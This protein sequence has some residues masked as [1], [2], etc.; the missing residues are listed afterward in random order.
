[1]K[2]IIAILAIVIALSAPALA[3]PPPHFT[4]TYSL[5][6]A[7]DPSGI[8]TN[9]VRFWI[10]NVTNR[11]FSCYQ[12]TWHSFAVDAA[13]PSFPLLAPNGTLSAPSYSF[14]SYPMDGM[15][16]T[17]ASGNQYTSLKGGPDAGNRG[18]MRVGLQSKWTVTAGATEYGDI[19]FGTSGFDLDALGTFSVDVVGNAEIISDGLVDLNSASGVSGAQ[20]R[21]DSAG[22][23][24]MTANTTGISA[25]AI[26]HATGSG[27]PVASLSISNGSVTASVGADVKGV[28]VLTGGSKPTC[29][30]TNRGGMWRVEGGAGVADTFEV[31]TKDAADAYAWRTLI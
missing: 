7:G 26:A 10:N 9:E 28:F 20:V 2:R 3:Q 30:S 17:L 29:D 22:T 24:D 12:G 13:A 27:A 6:A 5:A 4:A 31:C 21:T 25:A 8:C 23:A 16:H 1:M 14:S 19:D 15:Y 11:M 18:V